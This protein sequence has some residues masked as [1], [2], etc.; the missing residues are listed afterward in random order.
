MNS[1]VSSRRVSAVPAPAS[2]T[3][4]L[5]D[6][7]SS[8]RTSE[9]NAPTC[10]SETASRA[11]SDTTRTHS[12]TETITPTAHAAIRTPGTA[13]TGSPDLLDDRVDDR[14]GG[15]TMPTPIKAATG[16]VIAQTTR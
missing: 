10:G 16:T 7:A 1:S 14:V 13:V 4:T 6:R 9:T 11:G 3:K 15:R 5:A 12:T 2:P 8:G